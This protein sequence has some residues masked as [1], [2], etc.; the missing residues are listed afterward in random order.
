MGK[1]YDPSIVIFR[2]LKNYTRKIVDICRRYL[3]LSMI[4]KTLTCPRITLFGLL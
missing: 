2:L 1:T 4:K 3:I